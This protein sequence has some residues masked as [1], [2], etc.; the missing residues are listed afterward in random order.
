M[1][2]ETIRGPP[3]GWLGFV[4]TP[5]ETQPTKGKCTAARRKK[6]NIDIQKPGHPPN[7]SNRTSPTH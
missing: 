7:L 5:Q 3:Y 4:T 6:Y 1:G 2:P